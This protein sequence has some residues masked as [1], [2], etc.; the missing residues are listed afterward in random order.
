MSGTP[1]SVTCSSSSCDADTKPGAKECPKTTD[2]EQTVSAGY[3]HSMLLT[4]DGRVWTTGDN[5]FGQLGDGTT[6]DR[7]IFALV[8]FSGQCDT[9]V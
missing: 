7:H 5:E 3:A 4:K 6:T 2:C 1:G 8:M 9:T